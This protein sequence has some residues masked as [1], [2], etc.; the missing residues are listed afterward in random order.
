VNKGKNKNNDFQNTTQKT[1]ELH[2]KPVVNS[3]PLEEYV[4]LAP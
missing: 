3:C 1:K 4:V 2:S